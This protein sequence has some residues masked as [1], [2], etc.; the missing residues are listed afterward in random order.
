[1]HS[2]PS[3]TWDSGWHRRPRLPNATI[4]R[5]RLGELAGTPDMTRRP[6]VLFIS[7]LGP[8]GGYDSRIFCRS[9]RACWKAAS[10]AGATVPA[11]RPGLSS[12]AL[13]QGGNRYS[14]QFHPEATAD[15]FGRVWARRD[16]TKVPNCRPLPGAERMLLNV[17]TGTGVLVA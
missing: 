1:M 11:T 17:L 4:G 10:P 6:T 15:L 8:Q 14:V 9:W 3:H 16:P 5:I 12:A 13:D 2:P 7:Q